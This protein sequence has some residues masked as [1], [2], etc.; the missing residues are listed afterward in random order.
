VKIVAVSQRVDFYPDR[1]E[2]RDAL[3]QKLVQFLLDAG[4]LPI[5]IPNCL[6]MRP[7][8]GIS[9]QVGIS[10]WITNI[11]PHAVLLSG[12]NDIDSCQERDNTE[13]WLLDYAEQ[14]KL[15]V[16]GICRG[17]QMMGVWAG[18]KLNIASQHIR[19]RHLVTGEIQREVNS[20]HNQVI[21]GCPQN[22]SILASS[23]DGEIE[24]IRHQHLPWEGWMWH[25]EREEIFHSYDIQRI[26]SLFGN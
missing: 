10:K 3:D 4:F 16:L 11:N 7:C 8:E 15:P 5:P 22:F 18:V 25:P 9:Q 2:R 26:K 20:Y 14:N 17:M 24:A 23:Q 12:G 19:T 21:D 6:S 13:N 1:N